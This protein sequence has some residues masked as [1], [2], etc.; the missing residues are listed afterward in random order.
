[1]EFSADLYLLGPCDVERAGWYFCPQSTGYH[2]LLQSLVPVRF[3]RIR[4]G[5][6][7]PDH[8]LLE[9]HLG[10]VTGSSFFSAHYL[11]IHWGLLE[12]P[13]L[14]SFPQ[15]T[16][17]HQLY[18]YQYFTLYRDSHLMLTTEEHIIL[19]LQIKK[20]QVSATLMTWP[21]VGTDWG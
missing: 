21:A 9:M 8:A 11:C 15:C 18:I 19:N 20:P 1:M 14:T 12:S 3:Q 4:Y 16:E 5:K 13:I 7:T 6:T 10:A 2:S 17:K